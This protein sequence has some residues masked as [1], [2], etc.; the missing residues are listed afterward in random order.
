M[1]AASTYS[2]AASTAPT[3]STS[4][5]LR[6]GAASRIA[7]GDGGEVL[8][9]GRAVGALEGRPAVA[10]RVQQAR[11]AFGVD[12]PA[13]AQLP[14]HRRQAFTDRREREAVVALLDD[15]LEREPAQDARERA[16][17]RAD[18]GGDLRPGQGPSASASATPSSDAT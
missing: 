13:S 11:H 5:A 10:H 1:Q 17:V 2:R 9:E 12:L 15:V 14:G 4:V 7:A 6:C 3:R 8:E 16:G 18:R